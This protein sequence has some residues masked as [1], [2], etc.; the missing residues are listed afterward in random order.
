MPN[1]LNAIYHVRHQFK[2]NARRIQEKT[3]MID[4]LRRRNVNSPKMSKNRDFINIGTFK[5]F[6][7]KIKL[8][9]LLLLKR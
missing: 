2:G 8:Y 1:F 7:Q 4:S 9:F 5:Q 6:T 3:G